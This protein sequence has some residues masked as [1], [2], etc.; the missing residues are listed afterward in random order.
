MVYAFVKFGRKK[1]MDELENVIL[2][3]VEDLKS[4]RIFKTLIIWMLK[5]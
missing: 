4:S 3:N 1:P 5:Y 2:N